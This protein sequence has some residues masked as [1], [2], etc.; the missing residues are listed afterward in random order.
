MTGKPL[1]FGEDDPR[2]KAQRARGGLA[3]DYIPGYSELVQ[4]RDIAK[5]EHFYDGIEHR[6]LTDAQKRVYYERFGT[7]PVDSEW[8]FSWQRVSGPGGE[9]S[10]NAS[11]ALMLAENDG[12]ELV[13]LKAKDIKRAK[14][15]FKE[16]FGYGF[17]PAAHLMPDGSLRRLDVALYVM[18]G[19]TW[20]ALEYERE[21]E[22]KRRLLEEK[23]SAVESGSKTG[24]R[25]DVALDEEGADTISWKPNV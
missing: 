5:A 23:Q 2:R 9:N 15:E 1:L 3:P 18:R 13:Q 17:P 19:H 4:A 22:N 11:T 16:R 25:V 20:R 6:G 12:W 14:E 10:Y 24:V 7:K 8:E 21:L